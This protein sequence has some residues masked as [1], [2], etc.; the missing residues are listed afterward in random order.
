[1]CS[2][3]VLIKISPALSI[4]FADFITYF[5]ISLYVINVSVQLSL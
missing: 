4:K 1:M 3:V 2:Y 5:S